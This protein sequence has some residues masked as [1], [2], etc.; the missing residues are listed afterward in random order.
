MEEY[1]GVLFDVYT[2]MVPTSWLI[3][4]KKTVFWPPGP[5]TKLGMKNMIPDEKWTAY[6]WKK[7]LG[8][9][10]NFYCLKYIILIYLP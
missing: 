6:K 3:F 10:G 4:E 7:A 8:P 9:Y 5:V 1:F 2:S